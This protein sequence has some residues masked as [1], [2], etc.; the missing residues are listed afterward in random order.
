MVSVEGLEGG[1][2]SKCWQLSRSK[3]TSYQLLGF[4]CDAIPL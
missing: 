3:V 4:Y 1:V 2:L